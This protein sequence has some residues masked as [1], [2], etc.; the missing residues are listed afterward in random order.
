MHRP[1]RHLSFFALMETLQQ[2]GCPACR[3]ADRAS[4]RF[5]DTLLYEQVTDPLT[6]ARLRRARGFCRE[7][8][9]IVMGMGDA[10][11]SSIIYADLLA[12]AGKSLRGGATD[13]C[14]A[15]QAG[16]EAAQRA[17]STLLGHLNEE[18]VRGAY[19][20]GDGLCL[21]HL[22]QLAEGKKASVAAAI[23]IQIER[24]RLQRLANECTEFVA[25]SD[26]RRQGEALGPERNAWQRAARKVGGGFPRDG[27]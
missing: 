14:P 11:G 25:K 16:T 20:S 2:S 24:E 7:H 8:T 9:E 27:A 1:R 18:D 23:V 6:R 10:L 17:L 3:L 12:E 5:L 15:C 19:Q 4:R 26:Y 21:E 22:G 13:R